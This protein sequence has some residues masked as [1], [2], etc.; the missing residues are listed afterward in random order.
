VHAFITSHPMRGGICFGG[1]PRGSVPTSTS[2][3][4]GS[5]RG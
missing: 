3:A 5:E 1:N 4:A 2:V